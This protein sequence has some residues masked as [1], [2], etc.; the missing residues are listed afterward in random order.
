MI[1]MNLMNDVFKIVI[2]PEWTDE[3]SKHGCNLCKETKVGHF[4]L[5]IN[6]AK[7]EDKKAGKTGTNNPAAKGGKAGGQAMLWR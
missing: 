5:I 3:N 6:E 2:P 1:K 7:E 4:D